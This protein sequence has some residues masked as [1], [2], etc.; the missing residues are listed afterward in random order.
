MISFIQCLLRVPTEPSLLIILFKLILSMILCATEKLE[1][2][3][4]LDPNKDSGIDNISPKV[5]KFCAVPLSDPIYV[6]SYLSLI[7]T[8]T[9]SCPGL[10]LRSGVLTVLFPF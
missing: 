5:L 3:I 4:S 6:A 8:V 9:V 2:L 1:T 10:Y 7:S